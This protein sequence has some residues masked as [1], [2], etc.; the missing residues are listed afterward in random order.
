LKAA[1]RGHVGVV[2]LL[3]ND[4]RIDRTVVRDILTYCNPPIHILNFLLKGGWIDP[5]VND[6]EAL[7][8]ADEGEWKDQ[9]E[10]LLKCECVVRKAVKTRGWEYYCG[11]TLS[12]ERAL[13]LSS[14]YLKNGQAFPKNPAKNEEL[15]L[16]P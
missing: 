11:E 16:T 5:S 8:E 12:L 13:V 6:N 2:R 7:D 14:F 4:G 9:R 1:T 10:V 3:L 15:T